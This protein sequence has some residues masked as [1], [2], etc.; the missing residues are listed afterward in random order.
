[1]ITALVSS[2]LGLAGGL[3]PDIMREIRDS[4]D[5]KRELEHL[6]LQADMQMRLAQTQAAA[7][8]E[9][10]EH[11]TVQAELNAYRRQIEEIYKG[12]QG[13]EARSP[14]WVAAWNGCLRP[15]TATL[16]I[17]LFITLA[18]MFAWGTY[19]GR[20]DLAT[21]AT[22][23]WGSLVGEAIQAVLGYLFGYRSGHKI[24]ERRG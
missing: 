23:I 7:K 18:A 8:L 6:R 12:Q 19:A 1:M 20:A 4:R 9:E 21:T 14:A 10:L 3:V 17:M 15:L 5:H 22:L 2:V 11:E 16:I 13:S 24:V